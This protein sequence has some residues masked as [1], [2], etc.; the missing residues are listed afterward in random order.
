MVLRITI[1]RSILDYLRRAC[2]SLS[3]SRGV[4]ELLWRTIL[5]EHYEALERKAAGFQS[6]AG[7]TECAEC[8]PLLRRAKSRSRGTVNDGSHSAKLMTSQAR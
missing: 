2:Y 6:A 3:R 8:K 7:K 1:D 4:N 5:E